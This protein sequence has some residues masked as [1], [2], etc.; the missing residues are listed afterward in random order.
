MN[1]P[2][3][4]LFDSELQVINVGLDLFADTIEGYS[5]T[6]VVRI[7]WRPPAAGD[8]HLMDILRQLGTGGTGRQRGS[9]K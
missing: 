1:Q 2:R 7:D 6:S 5:S 3:K 8:P 9:E 4:P